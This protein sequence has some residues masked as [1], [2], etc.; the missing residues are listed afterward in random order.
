MEARSCMKSKTKIP[1]QA[2]VLVWYNYTGGSNNRGVVRVSRY[3]SCSF[4]L[5]LVSSSP[6]MKMLNLGI[7]AKICVIHWWKL[8]HVLKIQEEHE[9]SVMVLKKIT[10]VGVEVRLN[11]GYKSLVRMFIS[12]SSS[13]MWVPI[14]ILTKTKKK[15]WGFQVWFNA[16][17]WFRVKCYKYP[18][19]LKYYH[20]QI[21]WIELFLAK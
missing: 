3:W 4:T 20:H 1:E 13:G 11:I 18:K 10:F 9:E 17:T 6:L 7:V 12:I 5:L 15:I 21:L 19:A 16:A 8:V 2:V 14:A